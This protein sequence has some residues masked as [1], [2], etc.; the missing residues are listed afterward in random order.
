MRASAAATTGA[1]PAARSTVV[2]ALTRIPLSLST[3]RSSQFGCEASSTMPRSTS[4]SAVQAPSAP[5]RSV[6][7]PPAISPAA[8][9]T[10]KGPRAMA[11]LVELTGSSASMPR[12]RGLPACSRVT[13]RRLCVRM[14]R[15]AGW[16]S[17]KETEASPVQRPVVTV[18]PAGVRKGFSAMRSASSAA[19]VTVASS[20]FA[21]S[22]P[23][24]QVRVCGIAI[25]TPCPV[26]AR[27]LTAKPASVLCAFAERRHS[28]RPLLGRLGESLLRSAQSALRS[29]SACQRAPSS[30]AL[31]PP[32]MRTSGSCWLRMPKREGST[33][34]SAATEVCPA[35]CSPRSFNAGRPAESFIVPVKVTPGLPGT[36]AASRTKPTEP[37]AAGLASLAA[38]SMRSEPR[39]SRSASSVM[40]SAPSGRRNAPF[41]EISPRGSVVCLP[42]ANPGQATPARRS[43]WPR[44][45]KASPRTLKRSS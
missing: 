3:G 10:L 21:G 27:R 44:E 23:P 22:R 19:M 45:S 6:R 25:F 34:S 38:I 29:A 2:F 16:P 33:S 32:V 14:L 4:A 36:V 42:T 31:A 37:A 43:A 41:R 12:R 18:M 30:S 28:E 39:S 1:L 26:I 15:T 7:L 13:P 35:R 9:R 17:L 5:G 20:A 24:F 11:P 40:P 8:Q